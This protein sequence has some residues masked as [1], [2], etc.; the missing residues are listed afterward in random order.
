MLKI[1]HLQTFSCPSRGQELQLLAMAIS[2][3]RSLCLRFSSRRVELLF[4][5]ALCM[6]LS[7]QGPGQEADIFTVFLLQ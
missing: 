2:G 6:V 7:A 5:G 3:P 4:V 1:G